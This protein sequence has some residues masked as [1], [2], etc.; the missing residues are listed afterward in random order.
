MYIHVAYMSMST[1][2]LH[3]CTRQHWVPYDQKIYYKLSILTYSSFFFI[4]SVLFPW[5]CCLECSVKLARN[6]Q[7]KGI[8]RPHKRGKNQWVMLSFPEKYGVVWQNSQRVCNQNS[9]WLL[10]RTAIH[11][12]TH[13]HWQLTSEQNQFCTHVDTGVDRYGWDNHGRCTIIVLGICATECVVWLVWGMLDVN[14]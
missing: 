2:S 8:S 3:E 14:H 11:T 6:R 1:C 9:V 12:Y 5:C 10:R 4:F 7:V 13:T